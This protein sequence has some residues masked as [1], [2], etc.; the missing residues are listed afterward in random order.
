MLKSIDYEKTYGYFYPRITAKA[1][2]IIAFIIAIL[3]SSILYN[4]L[5]AGAFFVGFIIFAVIFGWLMYWECTSRTTHAEMLNMLEKAKKDVLKQ[6]VRDLG[7]D[8]ESISVIKP[9]ILPAKGYENRFG[10]FAYREEYSMPSNYTFL[11]IL[12]SE[13]QMYF[14]Q[15]TFSLISSSQ[16]DANTGEYFYRDIVAFNTKSDKINVYCNQ[17]TIICNSTKFWITTAGGNAFE[18]YIDKADEK[19]I[20]GMRQLLREKKNAMV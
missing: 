5:D 13:N 10:D 19:K 14:Y 8:I 4:F 1:A 18:T 6:A 12:F 20:Q 9:I 2:A 15:Y 11:V 16:Y 3:L 17:R 7:L